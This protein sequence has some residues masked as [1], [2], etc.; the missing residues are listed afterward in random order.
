L[1][2]PQGNVIGVTAVSPDGSR[3]Y[4]VESVASSGFDLRVFSRAD[5]QTRTVA[6]LEGVQPEG[7]AEQEQYGL[8]SGGAIYPNVRVSGDGKQL[9]FQAAS[10]L[11]DYDSGGT[12]QVYLYGDADQ[13]LVCVSCN[14]SG[15]APEG[16]G[17]SLRVESDSVAVPSFPRSYNLAAGGSRIFFNSTDALLSRDSNHATDVYEWQ[18]GK[19]SLIS[20]GRD[21]RGSYFF[22][23][24]ADGRDVFFTT[25]AGLLPQD[26]DNGDIDIY[27]ARIG[28]GFPIAGSSPGCAGEACQGG[29]VAIAPGL[30]PGTTAVNG[31]QNTQRKRVHHKK[32]KRRK[33]AQ[34]R[35]GSSHRVIHHRKGVSQ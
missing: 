10:S 3:V 14:P 1:V 7:A 6:H 5:G 26:F 2:T 16:T 9:L 31:Q 29:A 11:T 28:G 15:A 30:T 20:D 19:L 34:H 21:D 17:A 27:D 23:A 33:A 35:R 32:K 8:L 22:G 12:T 24:S 18:A 13:S 25:K 4:F